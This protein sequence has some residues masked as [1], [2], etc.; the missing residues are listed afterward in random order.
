M[1]CTPDVTVSATGRR[2]ISK[3]CVLLRGA[4]NPARSVSEAHSERSGRAHQVAVGGHHLQALYRF[5]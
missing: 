5:A 1:P 2:A 4:G 3:E